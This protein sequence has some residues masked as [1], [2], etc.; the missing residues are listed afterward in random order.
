[1]NQLLADWGTEPT[2]R[3]LQAALQQGLPGFA[4]G[5]LA[6]EALRVLKMR[7][8]SSRRRHPHPL[9]VCLELDVHE[10]A[11][12]RRGVQRL[13]GKAYRGGASAAAY[14]QALPGAQAPAAFGAALSHL[15]AQ[16]MLWW[17]W[18]NDPG[19]PQLP[20]LLDP[21][22]LRAH[23][24]AGCGAVRD[25][26]ALRYEPECRATLRCRLAD[27]RV[28]YGKTF[29]DDRG[30]AVLARFEHAWEQAAG[31]PMAATVAQPLGLDRATRCF[32]Q[33][34]APGMPLVNLA[35]DL[36]VPAL[37]R[38]GHALASLHAAPLAQG[39]AEHAVAH[40]LSEAQRRADKI[41]R[42]APELRGR[43]MALV[44]QLTDA[45]AWLPVLPLSLVHGDLHAEQVW[46][47]EGRPLLFDFDEFALGHPME[48][49]AAF[50]TKLQQRGQPEADNEAAAHAL[51]QGYRQAAPQH[52]QPQW[53]QWHLTVQALLQT[54]RAF[55]FQVPG[56]PEEVAR[57][58]ARAEACAR[59][60]QEQLE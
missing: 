59:A 32:W 27:G 46:V 42:V 11:H 55:I 47:H 60:L 25:V 53:L 39:G 15:P 10:P 6:I 19:L 57:R 41:A 9:T 52:W 13:Y 4:E 2:P 51:L 38:L 23:L 40:W 1:M 35:H 5:S 12:G 43:A 8:S 56:W 16:D 22:R 37:H 54:S 48:D 17:A 44:L 34:A 20:V 36:A 49:L 45:I 14:V 24:P 21:Q 50:V 26:Q 18:P 3:A 7:R 30:A 31:D 33:A 58:L 29:C 28:I